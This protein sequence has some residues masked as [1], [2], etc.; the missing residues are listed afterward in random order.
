MSHSPSRRFFHKT[1][2][3]MYTSLPRP[4]WTSPAP[5]RF[6][7]H[8]SRWRGMWL[9]HAREH[10]RWPRARGAGPGPPP[11]P[12]PTSVAASKPSIEKPGKAMKSSFW[13]SHTKTRSPCLGTENVGFSLFFFFVIFISFHC[14]S[15]YCISHHQEA[16][17]V[18]LWSPGRW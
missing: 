2:P 1:S 17:R 14:F 7:P 16:L 13:G 18:D 5:G 4:T 11:R 6:F 10:P 15:M 9:A 3:S 8:L 12:R